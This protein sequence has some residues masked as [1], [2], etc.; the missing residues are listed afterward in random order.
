MT[1]ITI[2]RIIGSGWKSF[3]R[4][5]AVSAATVLV[6][7]ITLGIIGSLIFLSA[8]LNF[9]LDSIREKVDVSVYFVTTASEEEIFLL[10][11]KLEAL[12]QVK[13]VSYTSRDEALSIFRERHAND[14]LTLQALDELGENPLDASLEVQ[15]TNPDQYES[16]V[17]FL[18]ATPALS[19]SGT[20]IIDR[21]NYQQNK[22][23]IDRLSLAIQATR[24]IGIVVVV[25]FAVAS[26]LIAFATIRLAIYS[27]K[28]E[29][30]VMRLVGAS[31]A[32]V[33]GPFMVTGVVTGVVASLLVIAILLPASW[34]VS[35]KTIFWF[36]GFSLFEYY[37]THFGPIFLTLIGAGIVLGALASLFAVR[38][39][40]RS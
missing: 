27:S 6:M 24:D 12:P 7:T 15:A 14:Q 40:L 11:D 39:Y 16:I 13:E 34:Y 1:W 2:K 8:L 33:R 31:N 19:A 10:Q 37:I 30:A 25:L 22:E 26:I 3:V 9:T 4:G 28:E 32:Y 23:V 36:G 38:K 17:T 18:E 35:G 29:I 5:G 20:S 21:I